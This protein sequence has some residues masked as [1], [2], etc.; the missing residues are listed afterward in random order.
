MAREITDHLAALRSEYVDLIRRDTG[1]DEASA[2]RLASECIA[3]LRYRFAG[4]RPYFANPKYDPAQVLADFNGR[5]RDEVCRKHSIKRSTFYQ[6]L[7]E[8]RAAE[9]K[10]RISS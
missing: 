3:A 1:C 6:L 7:R 2:M 10:V 8:R 5:N 9:K 4:E